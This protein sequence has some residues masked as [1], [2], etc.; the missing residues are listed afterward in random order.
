MP[1]SAVIQHNDNICSGSNLQKTMLNTK[2]I[3]LNCFVL[4]APR[5]MAG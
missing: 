2:N 4:L 1:L 5:N 3:N